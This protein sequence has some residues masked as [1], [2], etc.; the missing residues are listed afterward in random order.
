MQRFCLNCGQVIRGRSD[1]KFCDDHC[2]T[3]FNNRLNRDE[4]NYMRRINNTLKRNRRIMEEFIPA[5][6]G[7][8]KLPGHVLG[9][10]GFNFQYHTHTAI[11]NNGN[12]SFFCYEFGYHQLEDGYYMLFK[13]DK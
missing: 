5:R 8:I 4:N 7:E 12:T 3:Q 13:L 6:E 10:E 11:S 9:E 2:R 1:K